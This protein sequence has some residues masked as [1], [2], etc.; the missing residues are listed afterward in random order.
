[1]LYFPC[2]TAISELVLFCQ[3]NDFGEIYFTSIW[4]VAGANFCHVWYLGWYI[5]HPWR[6]TVIKA[7]IDWALFLEINI[8]FLYSREKEW[9]TLFSSLYWIMG[10]F[11]TGRLPA[12]LKPLYTVHYSASLLCQQRGISICSDSYT[13]LF[14]ERAIS[15]PCFL[16]L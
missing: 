11:F 3:F 8:L 16:Q 9:L 5:L 1:M 10:M 2:R 7:D 14:Y 15:Q 12:P 6:Y 4:L 13:Q